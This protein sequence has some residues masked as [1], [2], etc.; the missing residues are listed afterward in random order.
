MVLILYRRRPIEQRPQATARPRGPPFV[1]KAMGMHAQWCGRFARYG[2][3]GC[4][5]Q[6]SAWPF[7]GVLGRGRGHEKNKTQH[8]SLPCPPEWSSLRSRRLGSAERHC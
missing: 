3:R 5:L 1:R 7:D 6:A 8:T 4:R 2:L